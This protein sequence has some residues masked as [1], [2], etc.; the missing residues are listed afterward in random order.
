MPITNSNI[1]ELNK[2][3]T[4]NSIDANEI[5]TNEALEFPDVD[6]IEEKNIG[7]ENIEI[8]EEL[9]VTEPLSQMEQD[10][11]DILKS[12]SLIIPLKGTITSRFGLRDSE[13]PTVPKN[14]TGIDVAVNE[15]TVFN[16]GWP[17][18][19]EAAMKDDEIEVAVQINGK[20]RAVVTV[21]A[22]VSKEDAIA[23]GKAV[24]AD[25]L[26]GTIVK[27]I[28]VPGRIVNIVQK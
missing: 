28:Y 26:T 10:A 1:L 3:E 27:E 24:V 15:G 11:K 17:T 13:T 14:H 5:Q 2:T 25:K 21:P 20:T 16:A 6:Y 18:Y 19:D 4:I 8:E 7:G 22:D 12:K 9:K 23:A